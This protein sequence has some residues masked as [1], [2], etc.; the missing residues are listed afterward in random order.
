MHGDHSAQ[1]PVEIGSADIDVNDP[2]ALTQHIRYLVKHE[3]NFSR[4]QELLKSIVQRKSGDPDSKPYEE[5]LSLLRLYRTA[6]DVGSVH[7]STFKQRVEEFDARG[8]PG[9]V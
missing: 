7:C 5:F 6:L 9:K 8:V 2:H 4:Y 1:N 3:H